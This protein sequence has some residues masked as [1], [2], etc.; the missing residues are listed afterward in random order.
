MQCAWICRGKIH[1]DYENTLTDLIEVKEVTA[2]AAEENFA[3][4]NGTVD[5]QPE[6]IF[7]SF[8]LKSFRN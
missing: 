1:G 8:G 6:C 7:F 5:P 3:N 4:Q 2:A